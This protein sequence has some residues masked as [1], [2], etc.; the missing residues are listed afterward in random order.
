MY[1]MRNPI[2][3]Y[4]WGSIDAIPELLGRTPDGGPQAELWM[5]A[6]ESESSQVRVD[7]R[8]HDL[9]GLLRARGEAR[10]P[11]LAKVT[12]IGSPLSLQIHPV[13]GDVKTEMLY[14]WRPCRVLCGFREV[15]SVRS[16]LTDL[17]GA[18]GRDLAP[19][20]DGLLVRAQ[21]QADLRDCLALLLGSLGAAEIADVRDRLRSLPRWRSVADAVDELTAH[22]ADDPAALAPLL[23]TDVELAVGEALVC[24]PGQPHTYLSGVGVEV[25]SNS[26]A[27]V[28]AGLTSK[29]R[30]VDAF[31]AGLITDPGP[32][33]VASRW[34]G[35]ER[36]FAVP[37]V[38]FALGVLGDIGDGPIGLA[39]DIAG[40]QI[41]FCAEGAYT[42]S[43]GSHALELRHGE[44]AFVPPGRAGLMASGKGSLFRVSAGRDG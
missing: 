33:R 10:L 24:R 19:I 20:V 35:I 42:L 38:D 12:A 37:S 16:L 44:S 25:Q 18:A 36:V 43:S 21:R 40:G 2:R 27:V 31:L 9:A 3:R 28:R 4:D 8:W 5:G 22:H 32:D 34:R 15:A 11:F 39:D 26:D 17:R 14:A 7:R 23:L 6:Y 41:L 29:P 13:G 30:D 1:Q